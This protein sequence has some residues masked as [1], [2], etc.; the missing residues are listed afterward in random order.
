MKKSGIGSEGS[1][2]DA[3]LSYGIGAPV[4]NR[5][6]AGATSAQCPVACRE[7]NA[8]AAT[9]LRIGDGFLRIY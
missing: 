8:K 7:Q 3:G 4:G 2:S 1:A 6:L 5:N 9:G